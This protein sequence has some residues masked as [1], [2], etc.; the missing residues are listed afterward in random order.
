MSIPAKTPAI[1]HSGPSSGFP[2]FPSVSPSISQ[3]FSQH[4]RKSEPPIPIPLAIAPELIR[5]GDLDERRH[6]HQVVRRAEFLRRLA[7]DYYA[8]NP[9][10]VWRRADDPGRAEA[11]QYGAIAAL[12]SDVSSYAKARQWDA[13]QTAYE[14]AEQI[15]A[16]VALVADARRSAGELAR[17]VTLDRAKGAQ[18]VRRGNEAKQ[19]KA[20]RRARWYVT[21]AVAL[22]RKHPGWT[23]STLIAHL[24]RTVPARQALL[25]ARQVRRYLDEHGVT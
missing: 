7:R 21:R 13:A 9:A 25:S 14:K 2:E 4:P 20:A 23:R 12:T 11:A 15:A 24:R 5:G 17:R 3:R 6:R 10:D 18:L 16:T 8:L 22:R 1:L 19:R